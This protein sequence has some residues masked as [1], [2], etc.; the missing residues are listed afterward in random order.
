MAPTLH[1]EALTPYFTVAGGRAAGL[2]KHQLRRPE[3]HSPTRG[4]WSLQPVRELVSLASAVALVLP[5]TTAFSHLT[6]AR[7]HGLPLSHAMEA[8]TRLH[9]IGPIDQPQVRREGLAGHRMLHQRGVTEVSGLRVVDLA[10]TWVDLGELVGR[11]KPVGLDDL[12]VI[13]D[14]CATRLDSVLPLRR[15]LAKRVRP[16]GKKTLLEALEYIRVGSWSPRETMCRLMFVRVGLPEPL[17]NAPIHAS[18]DPR[19]LLGY[20][21]LVWRIEV[22]G[23]GEIKVIGEYQ[24]AE[25]HSDDQQRAHDQA[26]SGLLGRDGWIVLE[27]WNADVKTVD[28]RIATVRRFAHELEVDVETLNLGQAEPRFFSRHAMELALQRNGRRAARL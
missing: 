3:L 28:A 10:D 25:F 26:R 6:I 20:G 16:R 24:G 13:G 18:W 22:A 23:G 1:R 2:T 27:S 21:D 4:V 15:A 9:V 5:A 14:S 12:I 8:D 17:L 11:G 19:L 7:L